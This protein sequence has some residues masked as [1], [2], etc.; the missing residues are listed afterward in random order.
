MTKI[1]VSTYFNSY[2][3]IF[4]HLIGEVFT[5]LSIVI[6]LILSVVSSLEVWSEKYAF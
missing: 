5:V 1:V 4:N 3:N 6:L 2:V